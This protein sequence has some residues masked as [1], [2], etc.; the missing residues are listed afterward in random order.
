MH[1]PVR[2]KHKEKLIWLP[3]RTTKRHSV[4][5]FGSRNK[6]ASIMCVREKDSGIKIVRVVWR[7]QHAP[8]PSI[9]LCSR[10]Q[11]MWLLYIRLTSP[12][13]QLDTDTD[14]LPNRRTVE[15]ICG[16]LCKNINRKWGNLRWM[17]SYGQVVALWTAKVILKWH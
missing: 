3:A 7:K 11:F 15:D 9:T 4:P 8:S 1:T 5:A 17:Q 13:Q 14:I 2:D 16:C 6:A 12:E 10:G